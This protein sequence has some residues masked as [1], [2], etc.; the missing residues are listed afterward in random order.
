MGPVSSHLWR[1]T[2]RHSVAS[3]YGLFRRMTG[4]GPY[5]AQGTLEHAVAPAAGATAADERFGWLYP[6][7]PAVVARPE[8]SG[9]MFLASAVR[10]NFEDGIYP[11]SNGFIQRFSIPGLNS[12]FIFA[13]P[14]LSVDPLCFLPNTLPAGGARGPARGPDH[15]AAAVGG[16]PLPLQAGKPPNAAAVGR[17]APAPPGLAGNRNL[18]SEQ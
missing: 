4:V 5:A 8:V 17:A 7:A 15:Q 3:G 1:L 11:V 9:C 6:G 18:S 10:L 14:P 13:P 12:G 2:S 16:D